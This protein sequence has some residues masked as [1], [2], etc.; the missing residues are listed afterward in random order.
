MGKPS[1]NFFISALTE[2]GVQ[3]HEVVL[4]RQYKVDTHTHVI[5][6]ISLCLTIV[7]GRK[8]PMKTSLAAVL[9]FQRALNSE[10]LNLT[11]LLLIN[12]LL[13][14]ITHSVFWKNAGFFF[15]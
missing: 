12:S 7:S 1:K 9:V 14:D 8:F 10:N 13:G 3:P 15:C 4:W 6:C 5:N 11:G 2:L